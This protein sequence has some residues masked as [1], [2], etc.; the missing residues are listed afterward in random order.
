[1]ANVVSR[2]TVPLPLIKTKSLFWTQDLKKLT[3]SLP[4]LTL[5]IL[6]TLC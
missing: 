5:S 1:M 2:C 6:A 3:L 4:L